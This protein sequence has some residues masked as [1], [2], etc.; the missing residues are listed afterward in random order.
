MNDDSPSEK[1]SDGSEKSNESIEKHET[2]S[3]SA[4]A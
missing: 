1:L 2:A 3:P 4:S